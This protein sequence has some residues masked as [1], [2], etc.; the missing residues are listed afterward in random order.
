MFVLRSTHDVI[1]AELRASNEEMRAERNYFRD[2]VL[3]QARLPSFAPEVP[4]HTATHRA[5]V[6][7]PPVG[8]WPPIEEQLLDEQW[9]PRFP[10]LEMD[11][12][13]EF[14]RFK[15]GSRLPSEVFANLTPEEVAAL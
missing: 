11:T 2:R 5:P 4:A 14:W 10:Y 8:Q 12:L 13:K 15:Y 3:S 7:T 1:V 6:E 9:G